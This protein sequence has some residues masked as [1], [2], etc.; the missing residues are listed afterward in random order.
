MTTATNLLAELGR[1]G[2]EV[3]AHGNRLR[4]RPRS[5]VTPEL[6]ERMKV[7]KAELLAI[8]TATP[9]DDTSTAE[10]PL[11]GTPFD[12][13]IQRPDCAGRWGW[14]RPDLAEW[15][16]WWAR[17]TFD[18]LPEVPEGFQFG[19]IDETAAEV[20]QGCVPRAQ[21]GANTCRA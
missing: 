9:A 5:A 4:Y 20:R 1:L 15:Q 2:I 10:H 21:A 7:H 17:S 12:G 16:R 6:A 14:E 11:A 13:W 18:D 19:K 8:L 3:T